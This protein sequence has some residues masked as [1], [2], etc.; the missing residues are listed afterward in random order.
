MFVR[1]RALKF[2]PHKKENGAILLLLAPSACNGG[3]T[4]QKEVMMLFD[5]S[6]LVVLII[7]LIVAVIGI[8][9]GFIV[10]PA[11]RLDANDQYD[12]SYDP[13]YDHHY[14]PSVRYHDGHHRRKAH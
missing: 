14:D 12:A 13:R 7:T 8:F 4:V 3:E 11:A 10:K 6:D 1:G 5:T 9:I 2:S